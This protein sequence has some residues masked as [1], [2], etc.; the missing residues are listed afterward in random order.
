MNPNTVKIGHVSTR[1]CLRGS[2]ASARHQQSK[3]S[4]GVPEAY[5]IFYIFYRDEQASGL[6]ALRSAPLTPALTEHADASQ[7]PG[8]R[9]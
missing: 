8:G 2:S 6:A 7:T 5:N 9:A 1:V 3:R 4:S